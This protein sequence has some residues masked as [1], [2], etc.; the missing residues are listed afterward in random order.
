MAQSKAGRAVAE[1]PAKR[2]SF[3][4][5]RIKVL[6]LEGIHPVAVARFREESFRVEAV[7]G[8]LGPAELKA[9]IAD[10]HLLG[11][12]SKTELTEDILASGRR[13]LG[14]GAFCIGTNQIDLPAA[15]SLGVPVFNAPFSNTRS[16]AELVVSHC[17]ALL[18]GVPEKNRAAH[19]GRWLKS[20]EGSRE[21]RGK[22]IGIVGYGHIGSQVSILAEALGM[23]VLYHDIVPKLALG[24]ARAVRSLRE[25]LDVADIVTLHVP[26]TPQTENLLSADALARMKDGACLINYS[27]GNVADLD[28]LTAE[29]RSGRLAGAAVDVYPREPKGKG[30]RFRCPLQGL[31]NVIL[32]PHIGGSTME[33]QEAIG[34]EV[35]EKLVKF[36]NNGSTTSAVNVPEV[37]LPFHEELHRILHFH[38]NVPGVLQKVNALFAHRDV[39]VLGQ[40]LMTDPAVGYLVMDVSQKVDRTL[41]RELDEVPGTIRARVLF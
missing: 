15:A 39:N 23:R 7:P 41:M 22:T 10:A 27:R 28:A 35:S 5:D 25:L 26:G 30:S 19:D 36:V 32:T 13:L 24:N 34:R 11:I 9:R 38:R 37:E 1:R 3:P 8:S 31:P 18:R 6:L 33:A 16:V 14:V 17:I 12:R 40:Y 4:K 20:A 21:A 29:L 2:T